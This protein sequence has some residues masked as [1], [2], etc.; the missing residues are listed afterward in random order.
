MA[1]RP[2]IITEDEAV[3]DELLRIAA[4]AGV[5]VVHSP[6][7][8][9]ALWRSA[10]LVLLDTAAVS[11]TL[12][13]M[14]PRREDVIAVA[15]RDASD[16]DWQSCILLGVAATVRLGESDDRLV[17]LLAESRSTGPGGGHL[18][19]VVGACGGVGA[20]VFAA[21]LAAVA[22]AADRRVLLLDLDRWGPGQDVILGIEG[23]PG[24]HWG[25]L[26]AASGRL[27]SDALHEALPT[28]M[29]GNRRISVLCHDRGGSEDIGPGVVDV[30]VRAGRRAGDLIVAD[31]PRFV[32]SDRAAAVDEVLAASDLVVMVAT[33][34]LRSCFGG[35]RMAHRLAECG[36]EP[37]MVV[38]GPSPAGVGADD[39]ARAT[40]L[41]VLVRMRPQ[42]F[43]GRQLDNGVVPGADRRGPLARAARSVLE[44]LDVIRQPVLE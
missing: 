36:I 6:M 42:P 41:E 13:A 12:S 28:A 39:L 40:G 43:L 11:R 19:S 30:I 4:A 14:L 15:P 3:L 21:A 18:V 31:L 20:S 29:V 26:A 44:H 37:R 17:E 32:G 10:A 38:R 33:A 22:D 23:R 16:V 7:P 34:D 8:T 24:L 1:D 35:L 5:D 2:L 9:R 25:N 27:S